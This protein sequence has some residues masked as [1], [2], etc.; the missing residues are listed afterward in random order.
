MKGN[1]KVIEA[2]NEVLKAEIT[3]INQYFVH[4]KMCENWGYQSLYEFNEKNSIEEMKHAEKLLERMLYLEGIPKMEK[5]TLNIGTTVKEQLENDYALEKAAIQRLQKSITLCDSLGDA[6][7]S[8]LLEH[9]LLDEENH[10]N[11]QEAYLQ[12]I[13]DM[14]I[15]NFLS[16]KIDENE[17]S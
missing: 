2:L 17:K 11:D 12:E 8:D 4:A 5:D 13:K 9:I 1:P 3:A 16:T 6:G 7:S 15:E 14:G 10:A